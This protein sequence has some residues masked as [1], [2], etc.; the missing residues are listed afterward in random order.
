[1]V[2]V[3]V[4]VAA[5]STVVSV[6]NADQAR[7]SA[8]QEGE[9]NTEAQNQQIAL[10]N[11]AFDFELERYDE[12]R[13]TYG[14]LEDNLATYYTALTPEYYE[15][16]G[17]ANQ[18]KQFQFQLDNIQTTLQRRG[19]S[20]DSGLARIDNAEARA[21]ISSEAPRAVAAEQREFLQ[22]GLGQNPAGDVSSAFSQQVSGARGRAN[23]A[24][25][26]AATA[27]RL[28]GESAAQATEDVF[29]LAGDV[30]EAW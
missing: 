19:I 12:W 9:R 3:V 15:T 18:E 26:D 20:S 6:Y 14:G 24:R 5:A 10:E 27:N 23:D 2:W 8:R 1:M 17:L 7:S 13:D 28:A 29:N 25:Q 22:I 21:T 11:R 16:R 4:G 30:V